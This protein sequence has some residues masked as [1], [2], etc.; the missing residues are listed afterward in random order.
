MRH[1]RLGATITRESY[2]D[3]RTGQRRLYGTWT[4]K[5]QAF[6]NKPGEYRC[7][8]VRGFKCYDDALAWWAVQKANKDRPVAKPEVLKK[9]PVALSEFLKDWLKAIRPSIGSGAFHQYESHIREH[10]IPSLGERLLIE[11]EESPHL[12]RGAMASWKRKDGRPGDLSPLFVKKVWSTLRT[13][14]NQAV[15]E[16]CIK[17]NP[18][19]ATSPPKVE[20]K[21]MRA[22]SPAQANQ[23]REAFDGTDIGAAIIVAIGS[24]LRRGELVALR[25]RDVDLDAGTIR[26]DRAAERITIRTAKRVHYETRYKEPKSK[27][28]RRTVLLTRFA[29]ERLRRHHAEQAQRFL[30]AGVRPDGETFVFDNDGQ[31]WHPG[32]FGMLFTTIRDAAGLPKVRLH[33]LRH[34]Y[35]TLLI[36]AGVDLKTVS[37]ALGHSSVAIT[38]DLYAH[39]RPAMQQAAADKLDALLERHA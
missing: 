15:K 26:V 6:D 36:E 2:R 14:L 23:Y 18:C 4:V 37:M 3:K 33:D 39:V 20:R 31:A 5:H 21:E 28:S 13:A 35:A 11:L 17:S 9:K 16:R 1:H 27:G 10:L 8:R 30:A 34:T 19:D 24:G 32:P 12:I 7:V 25:W 29:V 38:M 22:L